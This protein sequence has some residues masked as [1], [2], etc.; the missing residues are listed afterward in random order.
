MNSMKSKRYCC[1]IHFAAVGPLQKFLG[2]LQMLSNFLEW[3]HTTRLSM[4]I[5]LYRAINILYSSLKRCLKLQGLII[6][7]H[8]MKKI[9]R[10]LLNKRVSVVR[11]GSFLS[12]ITF[13]LYVLC[14]LAYF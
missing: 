4:K 14:N 1:F 6:F 5:L 9:L 3:N 13:W 12:S 10:S 2:F 7:T 8:V 11:C